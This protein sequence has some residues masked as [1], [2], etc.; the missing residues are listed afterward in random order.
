MASPFQP[1]TLDADHGWDPLNDAPVVAL[2]NYLAAAASVTE[3]TRDTVTAIETEFQVSFAADYSA[4][5]EEFYADFLADCLADKRFTKDEVTA[6]WHLKWLFGISDEQHI[7]LYRRVAT[8]VYLRSVDEV[9]GDF[10]VSAE[11]RQF[12][13]QL[14]E[15]LDLPADLRNL[16]F[17]TRAQVLLHDAFDMATG[18]GELTDQ[19]LEQLRLLQKQLGRSLDL[20]ARDRA[21]YQ[22]ARLLWVIHHA[23]KLEPL[24]DVPLKLPYGEV[25]FHRHSATFLTLPRRETKA[26]SSADFRAKLTTGAFWQP[27]IGVVAEAAKTLDTGDVF[28][29]NR[30]LWLV[31]KQHNS[32][33]GLHLIEDLDACP[34]WIDFRC[35]RGRMLRLMMTKH[36]DIFAHHLARQLREI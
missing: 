3:V 9:L 16:A 21:T 6:V 13:T 23:P 11:E 7:S 34:A 14:G 5:L 12:L 31:G 25:C 35:E 4:R 24:G 30:H 26:P 10:A 22:R 2:N 32:E 18:D 29:T 27:E 28:I 36:V 8:E 20:D 17:D 19:E 1:T 15:Y 33:L